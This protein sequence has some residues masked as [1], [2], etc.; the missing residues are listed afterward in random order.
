MRLSDNFSLDEFLVSQTAA[1]K[2]GQI[3][4]D[5]M[6]PPDNVIDNLQ[7]L[8]DE[9]IQ[10]LRTL[11]GVPM[12]ISS[13]YRCEALNTAIGGSNRSQHVHGQAA[14]IILSDKIIY[15]ASSERT[16]R[17]IEN[18]GRDIIGRS[19]RPGINAN[20]YLFAVTC[21]YLD[22]L[23]V[24]QVIHEYGEPGEPAWIHVSASRERNRRQILRIA[25]GGVR[26]EL[27]MEEALMLGS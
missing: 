24:D 7:Y 15:N 22:D 3:L 4:E 17:V 5:Q 9:T 13:G 2:G 19:W 20:F 8:V 11:L 6:S 1:R 18:K 14:D 26:E 16:R 25:G 10:P 23:D 21:M 27:T 12:K